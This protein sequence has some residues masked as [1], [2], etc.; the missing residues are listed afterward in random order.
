MVLEIDI[1]LAFL[2][3]VHQRQ[4]SMHI[5]LYQRSWTPL[6]ERTLCVCGIGGAILAREEGDVTSV[7]AP[8][9]A[10]EFNTSGVELADIGD[11]EEVETL[12][13]VLL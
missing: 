2:G 10:V 9:D 1:S 13:S 3:T 6:P 12:D 4:P 8:C 11:L 7:G 5:P